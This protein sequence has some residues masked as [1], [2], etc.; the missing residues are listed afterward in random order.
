MKFIKLEGGPLDGNI[1][2]VR[3]DVTE[4]IFPYNRIQVSTQA[5]NT[6]CGMAARYILIPGT[7]S[8]MYCE[9]MEMSWWT[10]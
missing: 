10:Q 1:M 4:V 9:D 6:I 3:D 8:F 2:F 7:T 5:H